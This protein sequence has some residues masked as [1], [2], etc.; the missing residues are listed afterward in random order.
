LVEEVEEEEVEEEEE[1]VVVV[2]ELEGT[3]QLTVAISPVVRLTAKHLIPLLWSEKLQMYSNR[4]TSQMMHE[5]SSLALTMTRHS[6]L[7]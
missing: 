1:E 2:P 4:L 7:T 3:F 6:E 5:E